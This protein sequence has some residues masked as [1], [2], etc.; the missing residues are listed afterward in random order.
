MKTFSNF[1]KLSLF[2]V[3]VLVALLAGIGTTIYADEAS[4]QEK[5]DEIEIKLEPLEPG[6]VGKE[7]CTE[8]HDPESRVIKTWQIQE[9]ET[10]NL[11]DG[12]QIRDNGILCGTPTKVGKFTFKIT[13]TDSNNNEFSYIIPLKIK[14]K[15]DFSQSENLRIITGYEISRASSSSGGENGFVDLYLSQPLPF[16][17]NKERGKLNI[18]PFRVW[19]NIR[20]TSIPQQN[21]KNIGTVLTDYYSD[22]S[23]LKLNQM[24]QAAEFL[25][26]LELNIG[27]LKPIKG[28][29]NYTLGLIG[30][31][32]GSTPLGM[33]KNPQLV[34]YNIPTSAD[35]LDALKARYPNEN[36]ADKRYITFTPEDRDRFYKQ[37]YIGLRLKKYTNEAE[38]TDL[39]AFFDATYGFNEAASGGKGDFF[40]K[41]KSVWRFDGFLP[42]KI[43]NVQIYLFGTVLINRSE[44]TPRD[45]LILGKP[46]YTVE[47]TSND[48]LIITEPANNRD[49]F[50]VG[51]GVDIYKLFKNGQDKA[52]AS[53][54]QQEDIKRIKEILEGQAKKKSTEEDEK[55]NTN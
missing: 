15:I 20:L 33:D 37:F 21:S 10:K 18:H 42:I 8:L 47:P 43:M 27:S 35:Q 13:G 14:P 16:S 11:P 32:G 41:S 28:A 23:N 19:G 53:K 4:N 52:E 55:Q 50:R 48:V 29:Y 36:F 38:S 46:V 6:E 9:S 22:L 51:I 49:Y 2:I 5:K 34:I 12:L 39:P 25:V 3:W 26:G 40:K 54:K 24:T 45:A 1:R 30:A 7:Y 17:F 44:A 31:Y